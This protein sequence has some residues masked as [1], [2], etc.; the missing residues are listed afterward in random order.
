MKIIIFGATG[1]VGSKLVEQA[2]EAGHT[3]TAFTR[4][5]SKIE[6]VNKNLTIYEGDILDP[7]PV[8]DA[9]ANHEA[10]LCCLGAG[11]KGTVRSA[12]TLN[13]IRGMEGTGVSRLICQTTLG[14]GDSNGNLNFFWKHVMFG[15]F[16]K[17][18]FLDHEKQETYIRQ[19]T[20]DWTIIRPAA[21]TD[22]PRTGKYKHGF[23]SDD[24]TITLKISCADVADFMLRQ[25][26]DDTYHHKTPGLS[27]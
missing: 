11:R 9:I 8:M 21:F 12:G 4:D 3:V 6:V 23:S 14:A 22:G 18:A 5:H 27:Y 1:R 19:S 7:V 10:V 26:Y 20:L 17:E 13:I 2:L 16:L 15:W 25:L 24:R